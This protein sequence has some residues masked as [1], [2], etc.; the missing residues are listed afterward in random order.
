[1]RKFAK[2]F[3]AITLAVVL[4]LSSNLFLAV[5]VFAEDGSPG[6][7]YLIDDCI[8]LQAIGSGVGGWDLDKHYAQH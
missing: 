6:D 8:E 1:M 5:P 7:P 3:Q 4:T 2:P